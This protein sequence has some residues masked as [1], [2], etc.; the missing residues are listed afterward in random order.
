M[1]L[2]DCN[3]NGKKWMN[4]E[5]ALE[6]KW[7]RLKWTRLAD[8]LNME[9]EERGGLRPTTRCIGRAT[10][11][12]HMSMTNAGKTEKEQVWEENLTS[13]G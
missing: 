10:G 5:C 2:S 11:W 9:D 13:R 7:T 1:D 3:E 4:L 8:G 12:M 6:I